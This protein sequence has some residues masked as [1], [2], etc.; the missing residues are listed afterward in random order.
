MRNPIK[1]FKQAFGRS[2]YDKA[3]P[4]PDIPDYSAVR[5][6][7]PNGTWQ[8]SNTPPKDWPIMDNNIQGLLIEY[9]AWQQLSQVEKSSG[10]KLNPAMYGWP[11][12][13]PANWKPSEKLLKVFWAKKNY[14]V[15]Y[16]HYVVGE[17]TNLRTILP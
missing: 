10:R 3:P 6:V 11:D 15:N 1:A 7:W 5:T 2:R 8:L 12:P 14:N 13:L 16:L 17:M 9:A 4:T